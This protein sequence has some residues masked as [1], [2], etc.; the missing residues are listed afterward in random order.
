MKVLWVGNYQESSGWSQAGRDYILA[1]D[2]A[3]V[4]VVPRPLLI[5]GSQGEVPER[6]KLLEQQSSQGCDYVVQH[7]VPHFMDYNGRFKKNIAL[8]MTETSHFK[9]TTWP[10][11]INLMDEAW[12]ANWQQVQAAYDSG[13]HVPIKIVPHATNTDRFQ[14]KYPVNLNLKKQLRGNFSFYTICEHSSRK[15]LAALLRAFH[16]EFHRNEPVSLVIKTSKSGMNPEQSYN[17]IANYCITVKKGVK[18]YINLESYKTEI[19]ITDHLTDS[20]ILQLHATCDCFVQVSYGEGWSI[21]AFDA[22]SL[23]KTPIV[24]D[25]S[26]YRA[27]MTNSCGWM[28]PTH[29]E[30]CFGMDDAFS[31]LYTGYE[32]VWSV[33][34]SSL[35][36]AMREA[37]INKDL[38]AEK[39]VNGRN[40]AYEYSYAR[41]GN[42]MKE[43][44]LDGSQVKNR[45]VENGVNTAAT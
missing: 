43:A 25:S 34:V 36:K 32:N 31:D 3:G 1:L 17:I 7:T 22:M 37:Y 26:G 23:G 19:I 27:Y 40:R 4:N 20:Q 5:T 6:I 29:T 45:R 13:V 44:L 30:A 11:R 18:A 39:A 9:R 41:I 24:S 10:S 35:R 42:I 2:A 28:V 16:T 38:R 8:Y 12:V 33:D 15:N 21:P 14:T